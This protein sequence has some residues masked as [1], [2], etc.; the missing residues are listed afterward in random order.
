MNPLHTTRGLTLE[1]YS[2]S[3]V[4]LNTLSGT[5]AYAPATGD[6]SGSIEIPSSVATGNYLIKVKSPQYLRKQIPGS[7]V[8]TKGQSNNLDL[9]QAALISGD[10]NGDNQLS[11]LDYDIIIGCYSDL[12]PARDCDATRKAQADLSDDGKVDQD[13]YNL[14][15][16]ELS[17][18]QGE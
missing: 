4:L 11:N 13:D 8:L 18:Q 3:E 12:L 7:P 10:V 5:V 6:F 17:V 16:R 14:Y 9:A 15:I 2:T 1:I